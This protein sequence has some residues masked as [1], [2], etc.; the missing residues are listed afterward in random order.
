MSAEVDTLPSNGDVDDNLTPEG[1]NGGGSDDDADL[2]GDDDDA[3]IRDEANE[4][5]PVPDPLPH[6]IELLRKQD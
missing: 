3:E 6:S 4:Y 5:G 1:L 2:F